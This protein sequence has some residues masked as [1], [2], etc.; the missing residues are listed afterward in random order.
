MHFGPHIILNHIHSYIL[1]IMS[2]ISDFIKPSTLFSSSPATIPAPPAQTSFKQEK[3]AL[4]VSQELEKA[5]AD[6]KKKVS[7][8]SKNCRARNRR[9]R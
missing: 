4:L 7:S 8:I 5:I 6:C 9:F 3:A 2:W 1:C